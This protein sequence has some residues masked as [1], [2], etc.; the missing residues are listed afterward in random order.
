MDTL[1]YILRNVSRN[2]LRSALTILSIGFS[3]ALMTVLIGY[4]AMQSVWKDEASQH[5]RI[6][7]MNTQGFSGVVPIAYVDR[8]RG[9][10][11]IN[12]AVPYSWFGGNYKDEQQMSFA[13]FGTDPQHVFEVW[14]E[15]TIAP[16]ELRAWKENRRG[17]VADRRLANRYGWKKG[18]Q[19]PLK[20]TF[21]PVTLDLELVGVFDSPQD[22]DSLWFDWQYLDETLRAM[23]A[24]TA[25]NAGTI[26]AKAAT[27]E[28]MPKIS[29]E[30]DDRFGSSD[31]PTRT[32]TEA[33]FAQMFTDMLGNIQDYIRN[34]GMAV[35]FSL[36][37]VAGNTMAM[38]VRER[39]TEIAVLKAIGFPRARVVGMILGESCGIALVG[40]CLGVLAGCLSLEL[41]HQ[42]SRQFFPISVLELAGPWL[43]SL[44][45]IAAGIGIL[46]GIVPAFRAG[47]L[48]IVDGLR[49]VI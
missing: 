21:F 43:L 13:Q 26:F 7:V 23:S 9:I 32:Q 6:V 18:D 31:N 5:H 22:T 19:I 45:A 35:V 30:I 24:P 40:G 16:E 27:P 11:G 28:Q 3:L 34:I 29:Q 36:S 41:L 14:D 20:G 2:K 1:K 49:R 8:I 46:S 42:L 10:N 33:A 48:S 44:L 25:G 37:L 15:F 38:S 47:Q 17:C 39:T 4:T 12:S